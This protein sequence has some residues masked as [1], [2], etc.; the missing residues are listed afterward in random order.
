MRQLLADVEAA[1]EVHFGVAGL[2][3]IDVVPVLPSLGRPEVSLEG[4]TFL[5][6]ARA[7]SFASTAVP[8][9]SGGVKY[10]VSQ[11]ENPHSVSIH[12]GTR[13]GCEFLSPGQIGTITGGAES[14]ELFALVRKFVRKRFTRVQA[15]WVGPEAERML[16]AG[17]SLAISR[18]TP[19]GYHLRR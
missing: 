14:L 12:C 19:R 16:D 10:S 5:C 6:Q 11:R 18:K 8:Q 7:H 3:D 17:A 4:G 1:A 15:Y 2:L 13:V 9:R